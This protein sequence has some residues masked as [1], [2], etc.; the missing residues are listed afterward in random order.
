[1]S[2]K[3]TLRVHASCEP[4]MTP[5]VILPMLSLAN[6]AET[7]ESTAPS[8]F[9]ARAGNVWQI[10]LFTRNVP[11]AA[12]IHNAVA[13]ASRNALHFD[14][15]LV[16]RLLIRVCNYEGKRPSFRVL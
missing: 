11:Q 2:A 5:T 7:S 3:P 12:D 10:A 4:A 8:P 9:T 13:A 1:M 14:N 15:L 16:I 6:S